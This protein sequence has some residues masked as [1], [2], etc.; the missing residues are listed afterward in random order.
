[1][2]TVLIKAFAIMPLAI[3]MTLAWPQLCLFLAN[4]PRTL[5]CEHAICKKKA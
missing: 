3:T 5:F 1:M 4:R 2:T